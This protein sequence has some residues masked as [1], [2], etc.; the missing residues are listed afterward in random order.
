MRSPLCLFTPIKSNLTSALP[1]ASHC[2]TSQQARLPAGRQGGCHQSCRGLQ[3]PFVR[4][5]PCGST[6]PACHCTSL[7]A[8]G[9]LPCA[10]LDRRPLMLTSGAAGPCRGGMVGWCEG[11]AQT[12]PRAGPGQSDEDREASQPGGPPSGGCCLTHYV[13]V[14]PSRAAATVP[15]CHC[16]FSGCP[17]PPA[18]THLCEFQ[19]AVSLAVAVCIRLEARVVGAK[20]KSVAGQAAKGACGWC[21]GQA[22]RGLGKG[23]LA[24]EA[25]EAAGRQEVGPASDEA[26]KDNDRATG[27]TNSTHH[28]WVAHAAGRPL[29]TPPHCPWCCRCPNPLPSRV[30]KGRCQSVKQEGVSERGQ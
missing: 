10:A 30:R 16:H 19:P 15:G 20:C 3:L 1:L 12:A 4:V 2:S 26:A 24:L 8:S 7:G 28:R 5:T 13:L 23:R 27:G 11:L 29:R 21:V 17:Q 6:T 22:K 14:G 9:C 25:L 18:R